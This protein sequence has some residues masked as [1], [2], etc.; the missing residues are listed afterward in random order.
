VEIMNKIYKF[1]LFLLYLLF[2]F[3]SLT[4]GRERRFE[5]LDPIY[6]IKFH[7]TDSPEN[8]KQ[9]IKIIF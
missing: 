1:F 9:D 2:F 7:K 5:K 8:K 4:D 3:F 6:K